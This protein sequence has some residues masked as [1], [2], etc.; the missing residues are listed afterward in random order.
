M[1]TAV[2]FEISPVGENKYAVRRGA[3]Y[4]QV[5]ALSA[6]VVELAREQSTDDSC[7]LRLRVAEVLARRVPTLT[8]ETQLRVADEV[9][10]KL[11]LAGILRAEAGSRSWV[12]RKGSP[13]LVSLPLVPAAVVSAL[14]SRLV[15]LFRSSISL[16]VTA[17]SFVVLTGYMYFGGLNRMSPSAVASFPGLMEPVSWLIFAA[18]LV[19]SYAAHELGHA[20]A[21]ASFGHRVGRISIGLYWLMPVFHVD[22]SKAWLL[23]PR[24]R[25]I[26][27]CGGIY[28]QVI[29]L[30]IAAMINFILTWRGIFEH[31]KL[32]IQFAITFSTFS[33]LLS[34][35]PF[36]KFDGYWI[37]SDAAALPNLGDEAGKFTRRL[38]GA[39]A[40]RD[41]TRCAAVLSES[42]AL[43]LYAVLGTAGLALSLLYFSGLYYH[44]VKNLQL[45]IELFGE[46]ARAEGMRFFSQMSFSI[47]IV[48]SPAILVVANF[49]K[50]T[51]RDLLTRD[52]D[53]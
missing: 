1:G 34:L 12:K 32:A 16:G 24:E 36:L 18:L 31:A 8:R 3:N 52:S 13:M 17:S 2:T 41:R 4:W 10:A 21:L 45:S 28:F 20:A 43:T 30:A 47:L 49:I 51:R 5:D 6:E 29:V 39:I 44:A 46:G 15:G 7:V 33:V 38:S 23:K 26:V 50:F 19:V 9:L 53:E 35:F 27:N 25:Q 40:Q 14:A 22:V 48:V 37:Y 42:K 11:S